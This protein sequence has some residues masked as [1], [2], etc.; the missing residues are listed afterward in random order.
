LVFF[1]P[2]QWHRND[3]VNVF[4]QHRTRGAH[5]PRKRSRQRATGVVLQCVDDL[6]KRSFVFADGSGSLNDVLP[7]I[8]WSTRTE[9]SWKRIPAAVADGWRDRQNR[10]PAMFA[11]T[12]GQRVAQDGVAHCA[13]RCEK[14]SDQP[15]CTRS[16]TGEAP[17]SPFGGK[18]SAIW[19]ISAL[20]QVVEDD[21]RDCAVVTNDRSQNSRRMNSSL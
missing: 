17:H 13:C 7:T 3:T 4:D 20:N 8:T 10:H 16:N 5:A 18:A 2:M 12:P 11:D 19:N 1:T 21:R 14:S 15:I 6:P 9:R